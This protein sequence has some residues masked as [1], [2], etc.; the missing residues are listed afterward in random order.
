MNVSIV[1]PTKNEEENIEKLLTSI[2]TVSMSNGIKFEYEA[3]V[4]DDGD[5][6]TKQIALEN[7][8]KVVYGKRLGLG[9]AIIDGINSARFDI[10]VVMDAD[11]SHNPNSI[12][13]LLRPI[14]NQGYDMVVGSR[15]VNGGEIVGWEWHR[16]VISRVACLLAIPI[17]TIKDSTSGYFVFKK[18]LLN[19]VELQGKSWKI[20]LE[21]LVKAKPVRVCELPIIFEVRQKG[22]SK[23]NWKQVIA[24][25]KHLGSLTVYKY[26]KFLKFCIVGGIGA[27]ETFSITWILT[28]QFHL[29]YMISMIFA[30]GVAAISNFLMNSI[31]TF[32]IEHNSEDADYEWNAYYKGNFIQKWWKHELVRKVKNIVNISDNSKVLDIGCGS[33]PI[34]MELGVKN[35]TGVDGNGNKIRFMQDKGL[36]YKYIHGNLNKND[37]FNMAELV[38]KSDVVMS[39]EVIEHMPDMDKARKLIRTLNDNVNNGGQ[40]IIATPNY[41]D[42]KWRAIEKVYGW[43]MPSAYAHD[44]KVRFDEESLVSMCSEFGLKHEQTQLVA[45]CDM[46]CKFRK[47]I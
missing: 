23:F 14:V 11:F 43:L 39:L 18:S 38:E 34:A 10:I 30:V 36:P 12:P 9:Q 25:I 33:S 15:Y 44:H 26:N 24:Y 42:F 41:G 7:K 31:W 3:I 20:M 47:E 45:G 21:I 32:G 37:M 19:G 17:T 22:K 13:R 27:A 4:I 16:K 40:V 5:D 8:A 6:K 35:Y 46:V 1:I 29:W 28:E 2:K